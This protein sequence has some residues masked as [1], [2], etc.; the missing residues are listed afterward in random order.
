MEHT[1]G[2]MGRREGDQKCVQV[3]F[4]YMTTD[5]GKRTENTE[6]QVGD[7]GVSPNGEVWP[8]KSY[9]HKWATSA[10]GAQIG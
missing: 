7:G 5:T 3:W 9:I 8:L 4:L 2:W 1:G 10:R 6:E